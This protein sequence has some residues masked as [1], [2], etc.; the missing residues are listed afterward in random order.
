MDLTLKLSIIALVISI[1][2]VLLV[3]YQIW[4][5][6][7]TIKLA[8]ENIELARKSVDHQRRMMQ[9]ALL[10]K[11][12]YLFTVQHHLKDWKKQ[13]ESAAV[14]LQEA[15]E[16]KDKNIVNPEMNIRMSPKGLI[17]KPEYERNPDW[18]AHIWMAGAQHYYS[19]HDAGMA[20]TTIKDEGVYWGVVA[21]M[22]KI[23]KES[24]LYLGDLLEYVDDTIPEAYAHSPARLNDDA[25]LTDT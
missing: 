13:L 8:N 6:S 23:A 7:S 15:L 20:L 3:A 11:A 14:V 16:R 4:Q 24:S 5:N 17:W 25:F 2:A 19:M 9:M 21:E 22:I 18:L 10:P 12:H 1:L